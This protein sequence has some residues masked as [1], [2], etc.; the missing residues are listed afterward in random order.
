LKSALKVLNS[1]VVIVGRIKRHSDYHHVREANFSWHNRN[2]TKKDFCE[3][4][5]DSH[6]LVLHHIVPISW[7]GAF[8]APDDV[9]TVCKNHHSILHKRIKKV[10]NKDL[11][12]QYL[13]PYANEIIKKSKSTII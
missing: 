2:K 6:D 8:F 3:L 10:L 9:I 13:S 11:L 1:S 4:C 5:G 12:I 7:G